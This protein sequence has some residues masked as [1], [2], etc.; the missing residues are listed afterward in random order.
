VKI[1]L[2]VTLLT[3]V[4]SCAH[5]Q[6]KERLAELK[7]KLDPLTGSNEE[8]IVMHLG[9]PGEIQEVA[10]MKVYKYKKSLGN[11]AVATS[12]YTYSSHEAYD[13]ITLYFKN[14]SMVKWD[15]FVQR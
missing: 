4:T 6:V 8:T 1:A 13:S 3:L 11:R 10:G 15:A 14:G 9:A 12:D 7:N 5:Y 2:L